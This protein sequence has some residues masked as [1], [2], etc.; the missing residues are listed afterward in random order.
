MEE[1][2]EFLYDRHYM[3]AAIGARGFGKMFELLT[4]E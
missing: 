3:K 4:D 1:Y 2:Q